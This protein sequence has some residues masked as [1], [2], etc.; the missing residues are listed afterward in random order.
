MPVSVPRFQTK[1]NVFPGPVDPF[2]VAGHDRA[3]LIVPDFK[4]S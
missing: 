2:S 1:V 3:P 4:N